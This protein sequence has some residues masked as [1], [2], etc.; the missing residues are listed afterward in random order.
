MLEKAITDLLASA[1]NAANFLD[2][3]CRSDRL[4]SELQTQAKNASIWLNNRRTVKEQL[5][6]LAALCAFAKRVSNCYDESYTTGCQERQLGDAARKALGDSTEISRSPAFVSESRL[7]ELLKFIETIDTRVIGLGPTLDDLNLALRELM[8]LRGPDFPQ[9]R[10]ALWADPD[11]TRK[12]LATA[13]IDGDALDAITR[14]PGMQSADIVVTFE[15]NYQGC[16]VSTRSLPSMLE[17]LQ[18]LY[19]RKRT[20]KPVTIKEG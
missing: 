6:Q 4:S 16:K 1:D 18:L 17:F 5:G 8:Q 11:K 15:V 10:V 2:A 13:K 3:I 9:D 7:K 14:L 12:I 19:A 20:E